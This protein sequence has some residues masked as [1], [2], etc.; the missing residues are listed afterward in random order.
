MPH[1]KLRDDLV[2]Q[3]V[4]R[5]D[6]RFVDV[7]DPRS[8]KTL[9]FHER[10]YLMACA[11]NG[12]RDADGLS[13]WTY[14]ELGTA[15]TP[16]KIELAIRTL[17][18]IG[19]LEQGPMPAEA[20]EDNELPWLRGKQSK[21]SLGS[22]QVAFDA[23]T[24]DGDVAKGG[25]RQRRFA[26]ENCKPR[27]GTE[28]EELPAVGDDSPQVEDSALLAFQDDPEPTLSVS[29]EQ[30][31]RMVTVT[32]ELLAQMGGSVDSAL[33][34]T[35]VTREVGLPMVQ[36]ID[37][38]MVGGVYYADR[39]ELGADG[40]RLAVVPAKNKPTSQKRSSGKRVRPIWLA[41]LMF[42]AAGYVYLHFFANL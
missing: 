24:L 12:Q 37:D 23:A 2:A 7:K 42:A 17:H 3:P 5:G 27:L 18:E 14:E 13:A 11:M 35:S 1:P 29:F 31:T 8:G 40:Q 6:Q 9:R 34:T 33:S 30:P 20:M 15:V 26:S 25:G 16:A 41:M 22:A 39:T 4:S 36:D 38:D 28:S 32:P 19:F 10:E 21:A